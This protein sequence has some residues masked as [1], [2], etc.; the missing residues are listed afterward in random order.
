MALVKE[1][2]PRAYIRQ[3]QLGEG[4]QVLRF[5]DFL[6]QDEAADRHACL[7]LE[8]AGQVARMQIDKLSQRIERNIL[9]EM[10]VNIVLT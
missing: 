7:L 2:Q 4:E 3:G 5:L 10:L 6:A 8:Q 1:V 9:V